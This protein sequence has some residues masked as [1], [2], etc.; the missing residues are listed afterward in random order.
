MDK[1]N[2]FL[3]YLKEERNYTNNTIVSYKND[4]EEFIDFYSDLN[5]LN[6]TYN[7]IKDYL[8][9]LYNK[10]YSN[11]TVSRKISS[12]K[13]FYNFLKLKKYITTS[14]IHNIKYPK[15]EL[16]LPKYLHYEE[17][18]ELFNIPDKTNPYGQRDSLILELLY[19]TGVRVSELVNIKLDDIS[20]DEI[21]VY[22]KGR[23]ERIVYYT[24]TAREVLE[25]YLN[26]GRNEL[27][28]DKNS[29]YLF[30]NNKSEQL[31]DR[32]V[33]FI[34]DKLIKETSIKTK[35]SPHSLRHTFATHLLNEGADL[36]VVQDLLG[37]KN[38][39]TTGIYTHVSNEELRNIFYKSH[40]RSK[41]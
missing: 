5:I 8:M 21:K 34:L 33:R 6:L 41:E 3:E 2:L 7:D 38:I 35:I 13:S 40:P 28:K 1:L 10:K 11:S 14:P 4:I 15:K 17:I 32:G 37:H 27:L 18:E 9:F 26:N 25:L 31:T 20:E 29:E 30:I 23:K 16:K 39:S 19:S 12:V 24:D 36:K 22:G